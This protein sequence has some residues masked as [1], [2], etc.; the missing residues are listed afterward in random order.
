MSINPVV[1][2]VEDDLQSRIIMEVLLVEA[3]GFSH[4]TIFENSENFIQ[5]VEALNPP[6][7]IFFLDIHVPPYSGFEMLAMLREH[8][9]FASTPVVALTA[10][11]MNEEVVRLRTAG[12]SSVIAKPLDQDTFPQTLNRILQGQEVWRVHGA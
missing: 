5:R 4:V 6:P 9:R 7:D 12:F 2:Y 8:P 3:M 1:L 10:S 11:V